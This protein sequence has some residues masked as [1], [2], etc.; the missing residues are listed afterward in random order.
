MKASNLPTKNILDFLNTTEYRK[1]CSF[2]GFENSIHNAFQEGSIPPT[3]VILA[4]MNKLIKQGLVGG[5]AC[6]CR[7]D[8]FITDEGIKWLDRFENNANN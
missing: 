7:G 5:C 4:K 3:K 2:N 6:G 8:F 1:I